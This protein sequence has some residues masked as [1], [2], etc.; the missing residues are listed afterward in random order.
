MNAPGVTRVRSARWRFHPTGRNRGGVMKAEA[1]CDTDRGQKTF[2]LRIDILDVSSQADGMTL[3]DPFHAA[4]I[5]PYH[6]QIELRR[7]KKQ[8]SVRTMGY[9]TGSRFVEHAT[10]KVEVFALRGIR[11]LAQLDPGTGAFRP[12][13]PP[14]SRHGRLTVDLALAVVQDRAQLPEPGFEIAQNRVFPAYEVGTT[15][16]EDSDAIAGLK[17]FQVRYVP[18]GVAIFWAAL[19]QTLTLRLRAP[20]DGRS[21]FSLYFPPEPALPKLRH[22]HRRFDDLLHMEVCG[23]VDIALTEPPIPKAYLHGSGP[24]AIK[25]IDDDDV[26]PDV[27]EVYFSKRIEKRHFVDPIAYERKPVSSEIRMESRSIREADRFGGG[28][29][30]NIS[31]PVYRRD[32]TVSRPIREARFFRIRRVDRVLDLAP[33]HA[34]IDVGPGEDEAAENYIGYYAPYQVPF[35]VRLAVDLAIAFIPFVGDLADFAELN[36][37]LRTG[38][39]RWGDDVSDGELVLMAISVLPIIGTGANLARVARG[40]G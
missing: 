18:N 12:L 22:D 38:R 13:D 16:P 26:I 24:T 15:A 40:L 35:G 36:Y 29:A 33:P 14:G 25:G 32:T 6:C 8:E 39:N 23:D 34:P 17:S 1:V 5:R 37:A 7:H 31:V 19:R 28:Y 9:V 10:L 20:G 11:V 30:G 4:G 2:R 3:A 27:R 21:G